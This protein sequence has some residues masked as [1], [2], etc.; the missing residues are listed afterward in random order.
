MN[1][2][3]LMIIGININ[4]KPKRIKIVGINN[5]FFIYTNIGNYFITNIDYL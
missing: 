4:L 1:M 3:R 2:Y 5:L